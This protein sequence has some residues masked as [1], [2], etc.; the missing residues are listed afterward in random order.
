[1]Q[2]IIHIFLNALIKL[3]IPGGW[4]FNKHITG[5]NKIEVEYFNIIQINM[6]RI[7]CQRKIQN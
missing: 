1:M 6:G 2:H 4:G 5:P 3:K 7:R